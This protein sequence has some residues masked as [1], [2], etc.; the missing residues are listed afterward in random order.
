[1]K[2]RLLSLLIFLFAATSVSAADIGVQTRSEVGRTLTR[3]VAREVSGG[4]VKV[5]AVKASKSRVRIY[6]SIGLSYYPF[7]EQNVLAMY[8]SVRAVLPRQYR[9]ARI[10]LYTDRHEITELIPMACRNRAAVAK[11]KRQK[12]LIPFVQPAQRPLVTPLDRHMVPTQ[13]L[14]G[15]HIALWQSHGRYFDQREDRWRWQRSM[16]WMTCEDLYTQSYVV[17]YLVPMLENAGAT[18]LLPRERDVQTHEVLSDNDAAGQY[19]EEQGSEV[20]GMGGSGFA[21]CRQVYRAG[22]NPF[23]EGTT[24]RVRT[25]G[26]SSSESRAVWTADIPEAGEYAV[27]ISYE[28]TAE[29][30][31][32]VRYTVHHLGGEFN[33]AVNQT[34]GGGTWIYLGTFPFAA[35]GQEIVSLSNR[36]RKAGRIVSADAVKIGGGYGNIAR[37]VC[38]SLRRPG[39]EY[40]EETSGYPR[41]CEGARY[42]LQWAGFGEDVYTPK[43]GKDDYK[44]DFMS[45]AHW[46]NALM[47]G[48]ERLPDSVGLRIPVD[49][50]LAFHSDAGVRDNDEIIGTLGIYC[51]QD[52]EGRFDGGA[53]R[54]RSRDL[55][56][57]VQT[58]VVEDIRRTWEPE[59]KRRGLWNRAYYEARVPGV[60]TMLLELLSHQNFADMRYG[61][62]PRFKFMVSR[63]VYKGI[64]KYISSQ[65]DLPYV[66]QPL[67]VEALATEFTG[68]DTVCISWEPVVDSL[69]ATAAPD[70][71]IL[72]TRIDGGGF[73]NG[74]YTEKPYFITRQEPGRLY[75]YRVTAVNTGGESFP[76]E[77]LSACRVPDEKGCVLIVNGFDR[78]S[79]PYSERHDSL[80]GF[81]FDIDGGVPDQ[82]DISFI[83]RQ[84]VFD[85]AQVRCNVDSLALGACYRDFEADVIGGNT[86][87][88]PALHGRSVAAAGYSF[89]S[90]SVKAFSSGG[91]VAPDR[92]PVVD[93]ILGKQRATTMG[94]GVREADFRAFPSALR[95]VLADY[96][97]RGG[98]LFA[99]G[100]YLLSDL[101]AGDAG[102]RNFARI[103][104]RC[105]PD[106][107]HAAERG[108][109]RIVTSDGGFLRGE[110]GF[111]TK[112]SPDGYTVETTDAF[113]PVGEGA[114]AVMRYPDNRRTAAVAAG[115][116]GSTFVMGFPFETID[117]DAQRD[118]LMRDVLGFFARQQEESSIQK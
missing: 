6:A 58:Q 110:Y 89:C 57:L 2:N 69:D 118:R 33:C 54:Y 51:T 60:P 39:V 16:L 96:L 45:R 65:Y 103:Y 44:D 70:G 25:V 90:T 77:T 30:A 101:W 87:D 71:F 27:Y 43:E 67:P 95:E 14:A 78:V 18:V 22:E 55:T 7:R 35:G 52:G 8:D 59:W 32:D 88:Y 112:P 113:R 4:Y 61:S 3:I 104:L 109:V 31:D 111:A 91:G 114:F 21:H 93:L 83:G 48:S 47:G 36:S 107:S 1:M 9:K 63:A 98:A 84:H 117:G 40:A 99:S 75:S 29:S 5:Q 15:R 46:V 62:D 82:R 42:W 92:Y 23:R 66:V 56:D 73:D 64:L 94:R 74:R 102:G 11:L 50:A 38:D 79:A 97:G 53:D 28:S 49:M 20:W 24:R 12:K 76:S 81:F 116:R 108:R 86:F 17:P 100:C 68:E 115:G 19:R 34:M 10:E 26:G 106:G 85:P 72:Y 105:T 41:F 13:G 37:T 80:A